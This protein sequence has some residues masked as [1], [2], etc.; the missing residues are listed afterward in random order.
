VQ[1]AEAVVRNWAAA[2]KHLQGIRQY[3][4]RSF[5]H[6]LAA[7]YHTEDS[8]LRKSNALE[9]A[10]EVIRPATA[11]EV[12]IELNLYAEAR[13]R[14]WRGKTPRG[15]TNCGSL[16]NLRIFS[17]FTQLTR[18][19]P[20]ARFLNEE[21]F[22]DLVVAVENTVSV[23]AI[24]K[25]HPP[26]IEKLIPG[27]LLILRE[28]K[29][30]KEPIKVLLSELRN[31]RNEYSTQFGQALINGLFTEFQRSYLV[32]L[33]DLM[34]QYVESQNKKRTKIYRRAIRFDEYSVEH[35]L[36]KSRTARKA[37]REFGKNANDDRQRI[38]NLTPLENGLNYD[39]EPYS[40][41]K[42]RYSDSKFQ[43][44]K[45]MFVQANHGRKRYR[46]V[47]QKYLPVY[48]KWGHEQLEDRAQRLYRLGAVT[49]DF[50]TSKVSMN[51]PSPVSL[52]D[53]DALPREPSFVKLGQAL[54]RFKNEERLQPRERTTLRFLG[55]IDESDGDEVVTELGSKILAGD[56]EDMILRI[57]EVAR[58]IPY[59]QVWV[60][61]ESQDRRKLL[62]NDVKTLTKKSARNIITQV[63]K[64]LEQWEKELF[65]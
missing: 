21:D 44:T 62:S 14:I 30:G 34:D 25:S 60:E 52:Q 57:K 65:N 24:A 32:A 56:L 54:T 1:D 15:N 38:A 19:L 39:T 50:A 49:L 16:H 20:A 47:R 43:L 41:K 13:A 58:E 4:D 27:Y 7:E 51:P 40:K 37:A 33:W 36:V 53:P 11:L 42:Q 6:W 12:S 10:R 5:I 61:L 17:K 45:S 55:L 48:K 35:I 23:V 18:L 59:L 26:D 31:L 63:Q 64:C 3:D 28:I 29:N 2:V 46:E 9:V 22:L 8:P